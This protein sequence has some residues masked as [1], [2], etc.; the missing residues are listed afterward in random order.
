L[1]DEPT[2]SA[3]AIE[4]IDK[5]G[6]VEFLNLTAYLI[7]NNFPAESN[8]TEI[9]NWLKKHWKSSLFHNLS[10]MK[11]ASVK[12]LLEKLFR[13]AVEAEDVPIVKRLLHAGTNP[14]GSSCKLKD[15][16]EPLT[17]LQFACLN[18]NIELAKELIKAGSSIDK[19]GSG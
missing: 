7:S 12:A 14:N 4:T 8:G 2:A 17:P 19:P 9:Y 1:I 6:S 16:P 5:M 15:C 11:G 18:S 13:L 10:S 3:L